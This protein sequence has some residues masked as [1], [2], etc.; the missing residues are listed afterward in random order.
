MALKAGYKGIKKCGPGLKYDNV[1]GILSL[2]GESS[3][4]LDNLED[5]AITTPLQGDVLI[6]DGEDWV[7]EQP[8]TDPTED[9]ANLV[10]S[11]GVYDALQARVDWSSYAKTGVHN[12]L[13]FPYKSTAF[14]SGDVR[15]AI[16]SDGTL[17]VTTP[18][19]ATSANVDFALFGA[20]GSV[21]DLI[22]SGNYIASIGNTNAKISLRAA[23]NTTSLGNATDDLSINAADGLSFLMIRFESGLNLD[24]AITLKPMLR[25]ASDTETSRTPYAMTNKELTDAVA[26]KDG[27][28]TSDF[29]VGTET[30]LSK[31]GKL[32]TCAIRINDI[33]SA[34]AWTTAICN[35]PQGYRPKGTGARMMTGYSNGAICLV[36]VSG[37][38]GSVVPSVG[39]TNGAVIF[40]GSWVTD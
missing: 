6:Y 15:V 9:S 25:L 24:S 23:Y 40:A 22:P 2:E 36:S 4:K 11:G 26:V 7:N 8:D 30:M 5:V 17:T 3:L 33:T 12:I 37:Y 35:I 38:D 39:V 29:T 34:T 10:S 18:N 16:N 14:V 31:V 20:Y 19:G 32:V 1:N 27:T 28:V 13:P 21:A